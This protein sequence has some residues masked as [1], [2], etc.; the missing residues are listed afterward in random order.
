MKYSIVV[1]PSAERELIKL[2]RRDWYR[3]C[4]RI[5]GLAVN[6]RPKGIKKF[7][8]TDDAYRIRSGDFR[9]LFRIDD[10]KRLVVIYAVGHRKD[11]YR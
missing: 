1:L 5:E 10:R 2:A 8:G 9:V 4:D 6:P 7:Q 11:V 3:V